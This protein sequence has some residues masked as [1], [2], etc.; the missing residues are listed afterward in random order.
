MV[1][2]VGFPWHFPSSYN[3]SRR[4]E[5]MQHQGREGKKMPPPWTEEDLVFASQPAPGARELSGP[6][7]PSQRLGWRPADIIFP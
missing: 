7:E 2:F 3:Y 4:G 5:E 6:V 1:S